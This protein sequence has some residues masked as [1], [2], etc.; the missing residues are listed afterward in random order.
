[1]E[2]IGLWPLQWKQI[3]NMHDEVFIDID[4]NNTIKQS[5]NLKYGYVWV[6]K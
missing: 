5:N 1:M 6:M 2:L 3:E 4:I